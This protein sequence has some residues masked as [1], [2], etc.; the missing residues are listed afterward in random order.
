MSHT[1]VSAACVCSAPGPQQRDAR[2]ATPAP[3][4]PENAASHWCC[5][6]ACTSAWIRASGQSVLPLLAT[7]PVLWLTDPP[8]QLLLA[9]SLWVCSET[10]PSRRQRKMSTKAVDCGLRP[11]PSGVTRA[12]TPLPSCR[13]SKSLGASAQAPP[14]PPDPH[15]WA[16]ALSSRD[17]RLRPSVSLPLADLTVPTRI[18]TC[19]QTERRLEPAPRTVGPQTPS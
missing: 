6:S 1:Q 9:Q 12:D 11:R 19:A 4:L 7:V 17:P 14:P 16:A 15:R 8:M 18:C 2:A 10:A 5:S 3:G 13:V